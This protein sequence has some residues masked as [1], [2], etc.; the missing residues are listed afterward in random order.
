MVS[1]PDFIAKVLQSWTVLRLAQSTST[2]GPNT[3]KEIDDLLPFILQR[4]NKRVLEEDLAE[5]LEDYLCAHLNVLC[6]D[7]SQFDVAKLIVEGYSLSAS[8]KLP[9]LAALADKL[10]PG[11][12][13]QQ[14]AIQE[15]NCEVPA[16]EL[17]GEDDDTDASEDG[18]EGLASEDDSGMDTGQ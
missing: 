12:D 2:A 14:C 6:E 18:V 10:P 7:D 5:W 9:E 8:G 17:D 4:L 15:V 13:L 3:S 1:L 11:C 16:E